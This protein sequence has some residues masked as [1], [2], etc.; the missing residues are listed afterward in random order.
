MKNSEKLEKLGFAIVGTGGGCEA[1]I[2]TVNPNHFKVSIKDNPQTFV[3]NMKYQDQGYKLIATKKCKTFTMVITRDLTSDVDNEMHPD[4]YFSFGM[5]KGN[6]ENFF[7]C[8]EAN[9]SISTHSMDNVFVAIEK[10]L[11]DPS[12]HL[13]IL[14]NDS[15]N[16]DLMNDANGTTRYKL[17]DLL[18]NVAKVSAKIMTCPTCQGDG[19]II[20]KIEII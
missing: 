15:Q 16:F 8:E 14:N 7:N 5:Y 13:T 18:N 17:E 3:Q 2:K 10:L 11:N 9:L 4:Q 19:T 12:L 1:W 20:E 6:E